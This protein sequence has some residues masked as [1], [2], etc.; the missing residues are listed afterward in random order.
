MADFDE[1][2]GY[3]S[4][5]L[6][7]PRWNSSSLASTRQ[8]NDVV[9]KPADFLSVLTCAADLYTQDGVLQMSDTPPGELDVSGYGSLSSVTR[10][11]ANYSQPSVED[12]LRV[13]NKTIKARAKRYRPGIWDYKGDPFHH[14]AEDARSL[15]G[16]L[17]ILSHV[18]VRKHE[19][20]VSILGIEWDSIQGAIPQPVILLESGDWDL[21]EF[22]KHYPNLPL[23]TKW[24]LA[25]DIAAGLDALHGY[26][27]IHGDLK[28]S[29]I[30]V[31]ASEP[32]KAKVIDFSHSVLEP[33]EPCCL[34]GGTEGWNAPEWRDK[35]PTERLKLTDVYSYGLVFASLIMG[36]DV[37]A[38]LDRHER[39]LGLTDRNRRMDPKQEENDRMLDYITSVVVNLNDPNIDDVPTILE[40][41]RMTVRADPDCRRLDKVLEVTSNRLVKNPE[42]NPLQLKAKKEFA[43]SLPR[44]PSSQLGGNE[45][46]K[47]ELAVPYQA[48]SNLNGQVQNYVREVLSHTALDDDKEKASA[49]AFEL[50]ICHSS[51]FGLP[52]DPEMNEAT[53]REET[54][55]WLA[56]SASS[57]YLPARLALKS[58]YD[59]FDYAIP[60]ELPLV[61][62]LTDLALNHGC[63][64]ALDQLAGLDLQSYQQAVSS[65]RKTFCGNA[66]ALF[67]EV[68]RNVTEWDP[69]AVLT[70]REDNVVHFAASTGEL[71]LLNNLKGHPS[72]TEAINRRNMDGDTPLILATRA[73]HS[74]TIRLLLRLGANAALRNTYN[75]TALH[76][77]VNLDDGEVCDIAWSLCRAGAWDELQTVAAGTC[78]QSLLSLQT[79][80]RGSAALRAVCCNNATVLQVLFSIEDSRV[81]ENSELRTSQSGLWRLISFA[82]KLHHVDVLEILG[83]RLTDE[84]GIETIKIWVDGHLRTLLETCIWGSVSSSPFL[85]FDW[86]ESFTRMI[87]FGKRYRQVL[88]LSL[89]FLLQRG[90]LLE[91]SG[92]T[93]VRDAIHNSRRDAV[94]HLGATF[95]VTYEPPPSNLPITPWPLSRWVRTAIE[96]RQPNI[97]YDLLQIHY[98]AFDFAEEDLLISDKPAACFCLSIPQVYKPPSTPPRH[99]GPNYTLLY[100]CMLSEH[101]SSDITLKILLRWLKQANVPH[102]NPW[103]PTTMGERHILQGLVPESE[104]SLSPLYGAVQKMDHELVAELLSFGASLQETERDLSVIECIIQDYRNSRALPMVLARVLQQAVAARCKRIMSE[105]DIISLVLRLET[106]WSR[107]NAEDV[108]SNLIASDYR[109]RI[110]WVR[111]NPAETKLLE[112]RDWEFYDSQSMYY[113]WAFIFKVSTIQEKAL[114]LGSIDAGPPNL[115]LH[116]AIQS[117]WAMVRCL[118]DLGLDPDGLQTLVFSDPLGEWRTNFEFTPLDFAHWTELVPDKYCSQSGLAFKHQ[119]RTIADLLRQRGGRKSRLYSLWYQLLAM[120]WLE[121]RELILQMYGSLTFERITELFL[122][123]F[124]LFFFGGALLG[125]GIWLWNNNGYL[126]GGIFIFFFVVLV[127]IPTVYLTLPPLLEPLHSII[128]GPRRHLQAVIVHGGS[129]KFLWMAIVGGSPWRGKAFFKKPWHRNSPQQFEDDEGPHHFPAQASRRMIEDYERIIACTPGEENINWESVDRDQFRP[130]VRFDDGEV[131]RVEEATQFHG[132][133]ETDEDESEDEDEPDGILGPSSL[134]NIYSGIAEGSRRFRARIGS[135][136]DRLLTSGG[137][138]GDATV[139]DHGHSNSSDDHPGHNLDVD[140]GME[141]IGLINRREIIDEGPQQRQQDEDE[142]RRQEQEE[143]RQLW[144]GR[145]KRLGEGFAAFAKKYAFPVVVWPVKQ[146]IQVAQAWSDR[147]EELQQRRNR[148]RNE[149][150]G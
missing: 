37:V 59:A 45:R 129:V 19:Q 21:L 13:D 123:V 72:V 27:V 98:V 80:G 35:L 12:A 57:G 63:A 9:A 141:A 132:L 43:S 65:Y 23:F 145:G 128:Y 40:V 60:P 77:L 30:L 79:I 64:S 118:L 14:R 125:L 93:I 110:T 62:W 103:I 146:T 52:P 58:I 108:D 84:M 67:Y 121:Q 96:A 107:L 144:A 25:Y 105:D 53:R 41:L 69:L 87:R 54:V 134:G 92:E 34:K 102:Q 104:Y 1:P 26:G 124:G 38:Q 143:S 68:D 111:T 24:K 112:W 16:E 71:D 11:D 91:G 49:A 136:V 10:L 81:E 120:P 61:Q 150:L 33:S 7:Y 6:N 48:M 5:R 29:N 147:V 78:S 109:H 46:F 95:A 137:F 56:K 3:A 36:Q 139:N 142:R 66:E 133:E 148:Q 75:E 55:R 86:P 17:R 126:L 116:A 122:R 119:N 99:H 2:E 149:L 39:H 73:G 31:F 90:A 89:Q 140:L 51:G 15:L 70:D 130:A 114:S 82:L 18:G 32:Y 83:T 135:T 74:E 4:L 88:C 22:L 50:A 101:S 131:R 85:G 115:V 106:K 97:F 138:S 42:A 8:D 28:P 94:A 44:S 76:Y 117:N 47:I 127:L 100:T 20:I 113:M